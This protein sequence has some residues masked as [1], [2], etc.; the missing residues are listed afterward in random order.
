MYI[1]NHQ[2][3]NTA[4]ET[5]TMKYQSAWISPRGFSNEGTY[6]YGTSEEV[7]EVV[8]HLDMSNARYDIYNHQRLDTAQAKAEKN[9][10]VDAKNTPRH[11]ICAI[12]VCHATE[13][14]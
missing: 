9:A 8:N 3:G 14:F 2:D 10:R 11:E 7:A 12:G 6:I 13:M 1:I 5:E 4:K